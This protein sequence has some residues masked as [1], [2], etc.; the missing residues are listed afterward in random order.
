VVG[1][2]PYNVA[3]PILL[4]LVDTHRR[5][6]FFADATVMVQ[7]EVADRLL[8]RPGSK[9]YGA[10]SIAA[11]VHARAT[12]LLDL[13]PGAF[14]PPPRVRSSLIRLEFGPPSVRLADEA[15]FHD[16]VRALFSQRRKTLKNALV[17]FD[18]HGPAV[19]ALSGLDG[20]RRPETLQVSE[21]ARLAELLA[22]VRRPPV[23]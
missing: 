10:L 11:A 3:T 23:L 7:R 17:R 5:H 22:P 4:R 2:L 12:R 8:A 15:L 18:R 9:A 14:T 21:I 13:P 19:L 20:R 16:L 1:N 6:A